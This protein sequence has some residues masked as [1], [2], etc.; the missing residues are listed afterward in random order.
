METESIAPE[1][2]RGFF[3]RVF[4]RSAI[5]PAVLIIASLLVGIVQVPGHRGV[6]PVDEY[7]YI[8]YFAK[9]GHQ[10]TVNRGE[11]TGTYARQQ[12]GCRGLRLLAPSPDARCDLSNAKNAELFPFHGATSAYIYTPLY[13]GI[14]RILAEPLVF[15][16][17]DLVDAGRF[18]GALWLAAA[19]LFLYLALRRLKVHPVAATGVGLLMIG[20]LPAYWSNTYISTDAT[21]LFA[22][23]LMLY[24]ATL[25]DSRRGYVWFAAGAAFVTLLKVQ[26]L[27]AVAAA[28]FFLIIRAGIDAYRTRTSRAGWISRTF[29]DGRTITGIVSVVVSMVLQLAWTVY[30]SV[31]AVGPAPDMG[32][33][34][35]LGITSLILQSGLFID[36]SARGVGDTTTF[37]KGP[38]LISNYA[39]AWVTIAGVIGLLMVARWGGRRA[40]V[41]WATFAAAVIS[42]PL[43][44]IV[45]Y[46]ALGT[47][48]DPPPARYGISLIPFFLACAAL[49]LAKRPVPRW[50]MAGVGGVVF[51]ASLFIPQG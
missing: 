26:N 9:M 31:S 38:G 8:D 37:L 43:L 10:L 1:G 12:L 34:R 7:V 29:A 42:A 40:A 33:V 16:G 11:P 19:A 50:I 27:A 3:A 47:Y 6:S 44:S 25:A 41:A 49:L 30:S 46:A 24:L 21:A 28:V 36:G 22:G 32:K 17:V 13:F 35:P 18:V 4:S 39:V 45:T 5:A 2:R 23:G 14:T 20:S 15:L 48:P 51:I